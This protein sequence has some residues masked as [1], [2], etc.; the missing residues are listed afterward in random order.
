MQ[1]YA[2]QLKRRGDTAAVK[3]S[4]GLYRLDGGPFTLEA[5]VWVKD[6]PNRSTG[7]LVFMVGGKEMLHFEV[8]VVEAGVAASLYVF[9]A[10]LFWVG[11]ERVSAK[12]DIVSHEPGWMQVALVYTPGGPAFDFYLDGMRVAAQVHTGAVPLPSLN[13]IDMVS[14]GNT[15][16]ASKDRF[17]GLVMQVRLW[18]AAL[19][20]G[21][22]RYHMYHPAPGDSAGL[23]ADWTFDERGMVD[24]TPRANNGELTGDASTVAVEPPVERE[25][26]YPPG[27]AQTTPPDR[28]H[29]PG[30]PL[31]PPPPTTGGDRM[32][33]GGR[34]D[35]QDRPLV[36]LDPKGEPTILAY[37]LPEP[38]SYRGGY[39]IE[40]DFPE[41][42]FRHSEAP[43]Q[44]AGGRHEGR[45]SANQM[46]TTAL[47]AGEHG[48]A[49]NPNLEGGPPGLLGGPPFSGEQYPLRGASSPATRF[50][51]PNAD[52]IGNSFRVAKETGFFNPR[53]F[54]NVRAGDDEFS[55][56][57]IKKLLS[58]RLDE[59]TVVTQLKAG[60]RLAIFRTLTGEYSFRFI[61]KPARVFPRI[62]IA[63]S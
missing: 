20:G 55:R 39:I 25:A 7:L 23:L 34:P 6:M 38:T 40:L 26:T 60:N 50:T 19:D 42:Y 13:E 53:V 63:E 30:T 18:K 9:G 62:L 43:P 41:E 45:R 24:R 47:G 29:T 57:Q 46:E 44:P 56:I 2:L 3:S 36:R 32:N 14:I 49:V 4:E 51:D 11:D 1:T 5:W 10:R 15:F 35:P 16:T 28:P 58:A 37:N 12:T 59:A 22:I 61:R 33:A 17:A 8:S 31:P 52:E 21:T 27:D 54:P 48:T